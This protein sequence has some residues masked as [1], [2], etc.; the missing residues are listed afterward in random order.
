MKRIL[1]SLWIISAL[2]C[3]VTL[4]DPTGEPSRKPYVDGREGRPAMDV[5]IGPRE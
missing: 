4:A 1:V 2:E 5:T 3:G